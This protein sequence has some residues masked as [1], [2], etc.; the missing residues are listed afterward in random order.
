MS[1]AEEFFVDPRLR[2]SEPLSTNAIFQER[3]IPPVYPCLCASWWNGRTMLAA[4]VKAL[5]TSRC[6]AAAECFPYFSR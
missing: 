5:S 6:R 4:Q 3:T 2:V 1:A